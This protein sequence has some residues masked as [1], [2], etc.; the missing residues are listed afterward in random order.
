MVDTAY[1]KDQKAK[2]TINSL[3]GEI[4]NLSKLVEQ[5]S[6]LSMGQEHRYKAQMYKQISMVN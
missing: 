4:N 2:E 6:G 1:E 5:G 3:K